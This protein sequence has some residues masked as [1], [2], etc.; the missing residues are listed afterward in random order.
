MTEHADVT[1]TITNLEM[2]AAVMKFLADNYQGPK[3]EPKSEV[4]PAKTTPSVKPYVAP[5]DALREAM[6]RL[7]AEGWDQ[8]GHNIVRLLERIH[9]KYHTW[10]DDGC[11]LQAPWYGPDGI[12]YAHP[13]FNRT[14]AAAALGKDNDS[15]KS[16]TRPVRRIT[17]DMQTAPNQHWVHSA[18]PLGHSVP[19]TWPPFLISTRDHA[20]GAVTGFAIPQEWLEED[21]EA[22]GGYILASNGDHITDP[23][24][25]DPEDEDD[26]VVT[27]QVISS[28]DDIIKG[29]VLA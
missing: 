9:A 5:P 21:R 26:D 16:L 20:S 2:A 10:V 15:F 19:T 18:L 8:P 4:V 17:S 27:L 23:H 3:P 29:E 7:R 24:Y 25:I 6:E 14:E 1:I 28:P 12:L 22:V 13:R 11:P